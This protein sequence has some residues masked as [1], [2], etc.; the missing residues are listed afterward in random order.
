LQAKRKTVVIAYRLVKEHIEELERVWEISTKWSNPAG[1]FTATG[2][3][4]QECCFGGT[5]TVLL[6]VQAP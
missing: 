5:F 1:F 3:V 6:S 4:D 2:R